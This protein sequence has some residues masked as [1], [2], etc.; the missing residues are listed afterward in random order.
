MNIPY[1]LVATSAI[2][3]D[4]IMRFYIHKDSILNNPVFDLLKEVSEKVNNVEIEILSDPIIGTKLT[5]VRVKPLWEDDVDLLLCRDTDYAINKLERKSVEYFMLQNEYIVHGIRSH[6][7][8]TLPYL[9][10]LC[11]FKVKE[12]AKMIKPK[13]PSFDDFLM[14]GVNHLSECKDWVWG[15]D[16][17][18]L[19]HFLYFVGLYP[20]TLDCPQ[21]TAPLRLCDFS[22]KLIAPEVYSGISI[23]NC[24]TEALDFSDSISPY[25]GLPFTCEISHSKTL[26]DIVKNETSEIVKY[27]ILN[28][29]LK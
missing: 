12:V 2:Y 16:Q 28:K 9:A 25:T 18:L 29:V 20:L 22:A 17:A 14:W 21:Y 27:F 26:C 5:T 19:R 23:K 13:T 6:H 4:F 11:G 15:C 24:N 10:G 8:H 7:L 1:L 3:E